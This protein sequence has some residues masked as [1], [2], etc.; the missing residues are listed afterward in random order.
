LKQPEARKR[1]F[2][3]AEADIVWGIAPQHHRPGLPR[4]T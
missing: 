3:M 4:L 1:L 2:D